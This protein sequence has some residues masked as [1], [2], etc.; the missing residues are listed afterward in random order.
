MPRVPAEISDSPMVALAECD[1]VRNG[2]IS[3][4]YDCG[5]LGK[6]GT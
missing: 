3:E 2:E 5:L 6:G 1:V 4:V